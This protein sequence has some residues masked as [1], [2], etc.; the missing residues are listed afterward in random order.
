MQ[1][2]LRDY[3]LY[4]SGPKYGV[5]GSSRTVARSIK[6]PLRIT[7]N[8]YKSVLLEANTCEIVIYNLSPDTER[9]IIQQGSEVILET[10]YEGN[11]GVIFKG[12]VFQPIRGKE[13]GTDYYLRL[14]CIDGD[15]YLNL[16]WDAETIG[17]N[18]TRRQLAEQIMRSSTNQLDSVDVSQLSNNNFIDGSAPTNERSKVVFGC[19]GKYLNDMAKMSNSTFYVENNTGKFF[20]PNSTE[21]M[22]DAFL[23]NKDTGMIGQPHQID[24]G[25]EVQCLLNPSIKLGDFIKIDNKSV[26]AKEYEY[27]SV[28]YLL[29]RDGVYRIIKMNA[30]GDSRGQ[31]W[32]WNLTTITQAGNTPEMMVGQYGELMV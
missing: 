31:D 27:G 13:N 15:A 16:T 5:Y 10:G 25:V 21:G 30:V 24:N 8:I 23:I 4:I 18:N 6:P 9:E 14:L 17:P 2:F 1:Q 11:T 29:D 19:P 3:T 26:I 20:D 32:Y 22:K 12:Q 28:P 7:F